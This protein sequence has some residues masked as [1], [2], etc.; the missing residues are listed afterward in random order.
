MPRKTLRRGL[1]CPAGHRPSMRPRPDAAENPPAAGRTARARSRTFNEAAARCRGKPAHREFG[2]VVGREPSMRPR[3]DAAENPHAAWWVRTP[4]DVSMRPRPD[5]AEN[6]RTF[7]RLQPSPTCFNEAAA[8]CRGKPWSTPK[9]RAMTL[10]R[11]N[12][13]AARCRG[14]P[15]DWQSRWGRGR[16]VSMRPRPDAAEN[17]L[18]PACP[19]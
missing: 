3:P 10:I 16:I 1:P 2:A 15:E 6:P 8:R 4:R 17:P 5:A 19:G 11:F 9:A 18:H 12:E 14:K 7:V 13:A